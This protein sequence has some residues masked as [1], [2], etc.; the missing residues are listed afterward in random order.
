MKKIQ[1]FSLKLGEKELSV[2]LGGLADQAAGSCLVR[3]GDTLV[4]NTAQIGNPRPEMGFFPLTCDYEEK[5]Y[6]AGKIL[7]SR[8]IRREGRPSTE[9]TLNAR[10]IDRSVRPLFP[11][12][13]INEIQVIATCLSWDTENDP[14]VL[15]LNGASLALSLSEIPWA[16]P[17]AAVRIGRDNGNFV[18]NPSYEQ[19]ENG[20][21]DLV[22]VGTEK[23]KDILIN[24]IE[25]KANEVE[26]DVVLQAYDFALPFL[27]Q[28]IDFQNKIIKEQGKEKVKVEQEQLAPKLTEDIKKFLGKSLEKA[29]Y[30]KD[31]QQIK[32]DGLNLQ[33][34]ML[35]NFEEELGEKG[36]G[37]AKDIFEQET[38]NLIKKNI[39]EKDQRPDS[40]KLNEVRAIDCQ[41]AFLPRTHGSGI[42]TRGETRILSILTLGAPG[43]QQLI[44]SMEISGKKRFLHHYN[45]PP[46]SVGE[47]KRLG[48]TGRR[49]IGHGALA[50]KA[51][52]P[53]L[54]SL[55]K[56][57]Y[58][59]RVVSESLSS[60]GSTS[61]AAVSGACLALMDG[62]VPITR[63]AAGIAI[64]L[65]IGKSMD[66]FKLLTDIQ[67]PE[68]HYGEMDFKVAG[69][70]Q[71]IAVVQMDVKTDGINKAIL[72]AALTE[73][74]KA[75]LQII[76]KMQETIP[77]PRK[78]LSP[79]APRV[80]ILQIN[81][82]KIGAVIGP[83]GKVINEIIDQCDVGIDIEDSGEVFI[84]AENKDGAEKAIQW[85]KD[86]T[87]ELKVGEV[88]QGKVVK[89]MD[90][91]AFVEIVPGQDGLVHISEF[92]DQ[93]I[94]KVEDV[95]KEGDVIPIKIVNI[96]DQGKISL[97]AKQ[98]G[99]KPT[100]KQSS[101]R[102]PGR[103]KPTNY[104]RRKR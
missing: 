90:F 23:G 70:E 29:L 77:E 4:L 15:G 39:L 51:I 76:K 85:V 20:N 24:M 82:E 103:S 92:A 93:R 7:G 19:R 22:L 95:V 58:T 9:A 94:D 53:L 97:S 16:G 43:D 49:E 47:V 18:L 27:R 52:L 83:G 80:Y 73:G 13:L 1:S 46:Y 65:V 59:I 21:F 42:F 96:D 17:V 11:K 84:T 102:A 78:E 3:Y 79:Y 63:P 89:L 56:F 48:S 74:K 40:R 25:L 67:G 38:E 88:F 30:Q 60:N 100:I 68:D 33:D 26:E 87:R 64:G 62:G 98:A 81:P 2:Q 69:T 45:F 8:F 14:A 36:V 50:E 55:E 35:A 61:M 34:E 86:L 12:G 54:P 57:P 10:L 6:A 32:I 75:R 41:V 101:G 31:K 44:E 104:G 91:G 37:L 71:G 99:F 28:I 72:E 5:F 66:Q